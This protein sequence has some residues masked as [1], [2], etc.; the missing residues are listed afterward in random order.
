[1]GQQVSC[2]KARSSH[3]AMGNPAAGDG[4]ITLYTGRGWGPTGKQF[5]R[6]G[7]ADLG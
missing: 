1:M 7:F 6:E 2:A 5:C 4:G 3:R